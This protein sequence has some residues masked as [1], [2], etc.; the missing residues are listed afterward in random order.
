MFKMQISAHYL[1]AYSLLM[2]HDERIDHTK[3]FFIFLI[4]LLFSAAS[5]QSCVECTDI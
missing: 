1:A 5:I 2:G 3:A 4:S